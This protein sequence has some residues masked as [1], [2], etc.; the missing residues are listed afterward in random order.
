MR[1]DIEEE[2]DEVEIEVERSD[3]S[4]FVGHGWVEIGRARAFTC[5]VSQA[6]RPVKISTPTIEIIH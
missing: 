6:V 4:Q 2:V 5:W 1:Q 3:R